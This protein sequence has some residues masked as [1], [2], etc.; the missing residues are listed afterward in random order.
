MS[1][2]VMAAPAADLL[3]QSDF[4]KEMDKQMRALDS[5][6][7]YD[8]W[9]VERVLAPFVLSKEQR[10]QIPIVGDPDD[11]TLARVKAFYNAI[12]AMIEK[13]CG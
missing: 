10:R 9:S 6:G 5:Y 7:N 3:L 8:G 4:I 2:S 11:V 13:E 1:L 12:A